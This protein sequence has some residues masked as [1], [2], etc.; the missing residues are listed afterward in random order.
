MAGFRGCAEL[1]HGMGDIDMTYL[2]GPYRV[3]RHVGELAEGFEFP[4]ARDAPTGF[5]RDLAVKGRQYV[6]AGINAAP[7]QLHFGTRIVLLCEDKTAR[8]RQDYISPR[9]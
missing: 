8:T 1:A 2:L 5:F 3:V 4:D 9:A 7:G 6:F